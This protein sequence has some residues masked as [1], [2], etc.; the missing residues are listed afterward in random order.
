M[1]LPPPA[2]APIVHADRRSALKL[3]LLGLAGLSAPVAAVSGGGF[4][5]GV[6]SGEPPGRRPISRHPFL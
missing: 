2:P 5:H 3:G 6:A 4:T 1:T